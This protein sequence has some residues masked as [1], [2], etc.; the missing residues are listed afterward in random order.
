[1]DD[2]DII[3]I[4]SNIFYDMGD[5][6]KKIVIFYEKEYTD[7]ITIEQFIKICD[8]NNIINNPSELL[9]FLDSID[10][11]LGILPVLKSPNE[12]TCRIYFDNNII[13]S[14]EYSSR[15]EATL[16]GI[17]KAFYLYYNKSLKTEKN[18]KNRN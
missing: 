1:M 6:H 16:I 9:N 3:K 17:E 18:G 7:Y 2:A 11:K 5:T 10:I 12:W 4:L 8:K 14:D 15:K 13:I